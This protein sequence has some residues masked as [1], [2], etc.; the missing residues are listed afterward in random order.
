MKVVSAVDRKQN[1]PVAIRCDRERTPRHCLSL[2]PATMNPD[3]RETVPS[4]S[5][6]QTLTTSSVSLP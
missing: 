4:C 1:V 6:T 2:I 5:L 3:E